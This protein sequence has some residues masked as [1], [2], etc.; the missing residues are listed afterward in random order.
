MDIEIYTTRKI[1]YDK[2]ELAKQNMSAVWE[3]WTLPKDGN[4]GR[5]DRIYFTT[6]G[7][8]RGSFK[9]L[10]IARAYDPGE[11]PGEIEFDP[12][13]WEPIDQEIPAKPHQGFKYRWWE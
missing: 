5:G 11:E 4:V 10:G 12:A 2:L 6:E 9:I 7:K 8:V 3:L 1:L 13:T